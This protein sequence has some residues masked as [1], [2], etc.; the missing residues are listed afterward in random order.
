M[1]A[2]LLLLSLAQSCPLSSELK[3]VIDSDTYELRV[4]LAFDHIAKVRIRLEGIDTPERHTPEGK[5]A[6][7]AVETLLQ[8]GAIT[9]VPSG[10]RTLERWVGAVY[11]DGQSVAEWLRAQGHEKRQP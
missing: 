9:V 11:V 4:E 7:K 2:L 8:S 5:R 1:I 3:R 10:K 6:S